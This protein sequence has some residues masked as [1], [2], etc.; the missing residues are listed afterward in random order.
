M[1]RVM[2][3]DFIIA[4]WCYSAFIFGLGSIVD[5]RFGWDRQEKGHQTGHQ[6]R[7]GKSRR[8]LVSQRVQ[9]PR[10]LIAEGIL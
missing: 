4:L 5:C 7:G 9:F 6:T 3:F 10:R 2:V 1:R 8:L